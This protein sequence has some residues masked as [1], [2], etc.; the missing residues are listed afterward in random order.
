MLT[1]A[2]LLREKNRA[3]LRA[4]ILNTARALFVHEGYESFSL[5]RVATQ[6][7]YSPAAIYKHFKDKS[8]IF[9]RLTE[10]S[11]EALGKA[12]A[13]IQD[14]RAED[15]VARLRRGM[16]AYAK[17]GI[18]NSDHYRFAF[19]VPTAG[20]HA[21]PER[22]PAYISLRNRVEACIE[23]GRFVDGNPDLMAQ[24]LWSAVHGVTSLLIQ[25]PHFPWK[26]KRKL[27]DLVI[28][29]A[30]AGLSRSDAND[31]ER[32]QGASRIDG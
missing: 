6:L 8:E 12:T 24:A 3:D 7:G 4:L 5:R 28:D 11:F 20:Q 14:R 22:R 30:I 2:P 27:V 29:S 13:S 17:F 1:T 21:T 9:N 18:E 26:P 10:E 19:L 23:A 15:P 32:G 25:R 16:Q 31:I